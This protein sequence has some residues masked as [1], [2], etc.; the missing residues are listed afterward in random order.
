[1]NY[2]RPAIIALLALAAVAVVVLVL[3]VEGGGESVAATTLTVTKTADTADAACDADCSLREAIAAASPGDTIDFS[4]TGTI[5]LHLGELTI[6]QDLSINGPGAANLTISGNN[7]SRVF[8]INNGIVHISG[9]TIQNGSAGSGGDGGGILNMGNLTL[10]GS[11]VSSNRAFA[12]GGGI[13]NMGNLTLNGSTVSGNTAFDGG[14]GISNDSGTVGLTNVTVSGNTAGSRGGGIDN[15]GSATLTNVTVSGN[16][17]F[18]G[19][20]FGGGG[21]IFNFGNLTLNNS[22]VSGNTAFGGNGGGIDNR[23]LGSASLTN[24]TVSGNTA[25]FNGGGINNDSGTVGLTNV[26]VSGNMSL[27]G[28][29]GGGIFSK[30]GGVTPKNTII[31]NNTPNDCGKRP[32]SLGHNLDSDNTCEL[33]GTGDITNG[34]ANL[35][36]LAL[37]GPGTTAT[38]TLVIPSDAIDA[39]PVADCTV[40]TDQRGVT[41]PQGAACDI[42]AFE[43][44]LEPDSDGDG[45]PDTSDN[46]P[47]VP[48]ASQANADGDPFGDA[49]ETADCVAVPTVW[50]TPLGDE[51][52][53][54][55]TTALENFLGTDPNLACGVNA[56]P[57]DTTDNGTV[58][59]FDFLLMLNSWQLSTGQEGYIQRADLNGNGTV[60]TFDFLPVL[61]VWQLSCT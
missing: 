59:T 57:P 56:W 23:G 31:A 9:L 50:V 45:V 2:L 55:T 5:T 37:N 46:C 53:D 17:A 40:S 47:A 52:C 22:T 35:G 44:E 25:F 7:T 27:G 11:T 6:N 10:N 13:F 58:N 18:G 21:G 20:G 4:V 34:N 33:T 42:G 61:A 16:T 15:G 28:S 24:V 54:G 30:F 12:D 3:F 60:N 41:R 26:T 29:F 8:N 14:G 19:A 36:P 38:Q 32:A 48:N 39:V 1:M 43:L 51:D 49:C